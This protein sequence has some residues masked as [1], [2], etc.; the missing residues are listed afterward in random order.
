MGRFHER[1]FTQPDH[2][3]WVGPD[4]RTKARNF[5][6]LMLPNTQPMSGRYRTYIMRRRSDSFVKYSVGATPPGEANR[7]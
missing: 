4:A 6:I 5:D 1:P 3:E 7:R 2:A